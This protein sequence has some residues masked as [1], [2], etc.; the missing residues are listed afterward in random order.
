VSYFIIYELHGYHFADN[1]SLVEFAE[2]VIVE[3]NVEWPYQIVSL[4]PH[5]HG[6][7]P[8]VTIY[9]EILPGSEEGSRQALEKVLRIYYPTMTVTIPPHPPRG[10]LP[11]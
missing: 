9:W 3:L 1:T 2:Q 5:I 8:I 11:D 7:R 10:R 4:V 6:S